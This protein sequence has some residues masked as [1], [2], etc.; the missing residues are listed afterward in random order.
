MKVTSNGLP[1]RYLAALKKYLGQKPPASL[2]LAQG[3]GRQ[4]VALRLETLDLARMHE[5]ALASLPVPADGSRAMLARATRFFNE[6]I[7]PIEKTHHAALR[8]NVR[9][10]QA[11]KT[12][13]RCN[14]HLAVSK[15]S[16]KQ[17]IV[18]R[19]SAEDALLKSEAHS[20]R[21]L[22]ES[23]RLQEHLRGL[24]RQILASQEDGR[25]EISR[26]LQDEVAQT[27]LGINVRL[28]TLKKEASLNVRN[29]KKEI[30]STQRLVD[31]SVN[32]IKRFARELGTQH[33]Q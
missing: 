23:H 13:D 17:S 25:R 33:E 32:S 2:E 3:L 26:D 6:A 1:G 30:A 4:A 11:H 18:R 8:T 20:T 28:L 15:R 12:L 9:L 29:F 7:S 16:L 14:G 5:R 10:T 22:E 19:K 27:L 24:T 31:N 21:L